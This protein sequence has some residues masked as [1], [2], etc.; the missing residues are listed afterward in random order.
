M[1][2]I[3]AATLP[4]APSGTTSIYCATFQMAWDQ[5]CNHLGGKNLIPIY[6]PNP[7]IEALNLSR[8]FE[9]ES[10]DEKE[11]I[12]KAGFIPGIVEEIYEEMERKFGKRVVELPPSGDTLA[13][14]YLLKLLQFSTPFTKYVEPIRALVFKETPVESFGFNEWTKNKVFCYRYQ[15]D[16][17]SDDYTVEIDLGNDLLCFTKYGGYVPLTPNEIELSSQGIRRK[18]NRVIN[19]GRV[20]VPILNFETLEEFPEV[21]VPILNQ[22]GGAITQALQYVKFGLDEKGVS[23]ESYALIG[24]SGS[25]GPVIAPIDFLFNTTFYV[26]LISKKTGR[27]YFVVKVDS[28]EGMNKL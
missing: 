6:R 28:T 24:Y 19:I 27:S 20:R 1:K 11:Y 22:I 5:L 10:F 21:C 3:P 17:T 13:F 7:T 18:E 12:A 15:D 16:G 23:L 25:A 8:G 4:F 26:E 2:L 9:L 14:A